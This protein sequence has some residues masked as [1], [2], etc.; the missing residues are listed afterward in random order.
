MPPLAKLKPSDHRL[1]TSAM[2]PA[3]R[4]PHAF[5]CTPSAAHPRQ[6]TFNSTRFP[7]QTNSSYGPMKSLRAHQ[8][9]VRVA[10]AIITVG[11]AFRQPA[12]WAD[13]V[14]TGARLPTVLCVP[15]AA[16]TSGTGR[17]SFPPV[18]A[19]HVQHRESQT[20]NLL[21]GIDAPSTWRPVAAGLY[22]PDEPP[23]VSFCRMVQL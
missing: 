17:V 5:R 8:A 20:S 19:L 1:S 14:Y 12:V 3:L 16:W 7:A 4:W 6:H 18:S 23:S 2:S 22:F 21:F 9:S 13:S 15:N 11:V 10:V